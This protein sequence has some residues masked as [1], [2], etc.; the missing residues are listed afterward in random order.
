MIVSS[1]LFE[2]YLECG[3][4]CWLR[5]RAELS[6]GNTYAEWARLK[7]ETYYDDGCKRLLAMFP[8]SCAIAP[9][10]PKHAKDVK[11]RVATEVSLQT[12]GLESRLQA[13]EKVP[14]EGRAKPSSLSLPFPIHQQTHQERQA[15]ACVRRAGV[16]RSD[17]T[18]PELWQHHLWRRPRYVQSEAFFSSQHGPKRDRGST[19]ALSP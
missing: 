7:N 12:S 11:W 4:K 2:A 16:H 8:E 10:I 5:A 6:A 1:P 3:T 13:I 18:R 15:V 17:G 19:R 9:P 14:S